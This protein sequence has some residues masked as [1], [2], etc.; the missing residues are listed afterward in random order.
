MPLSPLR[1][2]NERAVEVSPAETVMPSRTD[3]FDFDSGQIRGMIDGEQALRQFVR[4][5][6][7]TERYRY[8]IYDGQYG[9]E[10]FRLIGENVTDELLRAEIPRMIREALIYDDRIADVNSFEFRM[11][12][13]RLYVSFRV[14]A[15]NGIITEQEV[16]V[17][18]P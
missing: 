17:I 4:K 8:V 18:W 5:A 12:G 7:V 2:A 15:A 16:P 3:H 1:Q 13:D 10:M 14:E 6:L 9:N 11:E